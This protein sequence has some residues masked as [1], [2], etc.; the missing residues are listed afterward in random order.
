MST[1]EPR[2]KNY[3]L[4]S[5][6]SAEDQMAEDWFESAPQELEMIH[7]AKNPASVRVG[8]RLVYYAAGHT[9]LLGVVEVFTKPQFDAQL[10]RWQY[11]CRVKPRLMIKDI[12]R[13]PSIDVLNVPGGRDFR[14]TVMQMDYT[15]LDDLERNRALAAI[16]SAIDEDK[17]DIRAPG[18]QDRV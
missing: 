18:L 13:A 16:E 6:G 5:V 15:L 1:W 17:G 4:K 11:W 9:K 12:D 10:K 7:F 8:D 3:F 14:K 2:P